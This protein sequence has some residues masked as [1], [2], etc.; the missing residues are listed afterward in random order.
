MNKNE[1]LNEFFKFLNSEHSRISSRIIGKCLLINGHGG[2]EP[3]YPEMNKVTGLSVKIIENILAGIH[4]NDDDYETLEN[5]VDE[6]LKKAG[7]EPYE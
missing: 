5:Y 2:N 1:R 6:R 7:V 3:N 4:D